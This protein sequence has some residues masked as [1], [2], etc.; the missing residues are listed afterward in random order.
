MNY[1]PSKTA[2]SLSR[3]LV[4][5]DMIM[6]DSV[7][8][9]DKEIR[10]GAEDAYREL[11]DFNLRGEVVTLPAALGFEGFSK[12]IDERAAVC[13]ALAMCT[14]ERDTA[15]IG[16]YLDRKYSDAKIR[17]CDGISATPS[18]VPRF[19]V[20][21]DGYVAG[22]MAGQMLDF[23]L[24]GKGKVAMFTHSKEMTVHIA[25]SNGFEDY[26]S[27]SS[28][29]LCGIYEH[30]DDPQR[31]ETEARRLMKEHPDID[32]I[33]IGTAN[34]AT[35][36]RYLEKIGMADKIRIVASDFNKE[37]SQ[38]IDRGTVEATIFQN[39]HKIGYLMIKTLYETIAEGKELDKR[40]LLL[41][42]QVIMKANKK[43][44]EAANR[45]Y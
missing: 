26:I 23:M 15:K 37:M 13:D 27:K 28:M 19:M 1:H 25:T 3:S 4:R 40:E 36:C 11:Y 41:E 9:Y 24:Q 21:V 33:Y 45:I 17:I 44:Y 6:L 2:S 31:A 8:E 34:F 16:E 7:F 14:G 35:I 12:A 18:D 5:I 20:G 39:P 38:M 29:E 30:Y 43:L 10:H 22:N 42:P 32:G